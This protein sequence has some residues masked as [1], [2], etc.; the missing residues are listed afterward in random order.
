MTSQDSN[1][2]RRNRVHSRAIC[3]EV[4]EGPRA[5]LTENPNRLPPYL[6]SLTKLLD[7]AERGDVALKNSIEIDLR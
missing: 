6:L 7:S 4:G 1:D 3:T 5:T 2:V